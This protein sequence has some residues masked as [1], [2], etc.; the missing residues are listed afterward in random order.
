MANGEVAWAFRRRTECFR[1]QTAVL[2]HS[3]RGV[4]HETE[5]GATA[6]LN[7]RVFSSV[8]RSETRV[9]AGWSASRNPGAVDGRFVRL[10]L[11]MT[12]WD[13]LG[14][15]MFARER[16]CFFDGYEAVAHPITIEIAH[17]HLVVARHRRRR[18]AS[19]NRSIR[20]ARRQTGH[21]E[22]GGFHANAH[23]SSCRT[24]AGFCVC[25]RVHLVVLRILQTDLSVGL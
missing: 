10:F 25:H 6:V 16:H 21:R 1:R 9:A 12:G 13:L 15:M 22:C 2:L 19:A 8:H 20:S 3:R 18:R 24:S 7:V 11:T 4:R 14:R 23:R 17:G 5:A